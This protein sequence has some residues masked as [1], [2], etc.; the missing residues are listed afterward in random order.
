MRRHDTSCARVAQEA[1]SIEPVYPLARKWLDAAR[2]RAEA[3]AHAAER[4]LLLL[5]DAPTARRAKP[6]RTSAAGAADGASRAARRA[7]SQQ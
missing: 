5:D 7:R 4:E 3:A 1:L 6:G 2:V